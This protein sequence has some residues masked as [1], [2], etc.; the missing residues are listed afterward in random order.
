VVAQIPDTFIGAA[1]NVAYVA[2]A[3][4]DISETNPLVT[5]SRDITDT[6]TTATDND[7]QADLTVV[8]VSPVV[9]ALAR[10]GS[11]VELVALLAG[12]TCVV[13]GLVAVG[14]ARRR[15]AA[16]RI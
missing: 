2:A 6:S 3:P 10:T 4:S 5:P 7:A 14:V 15:A 13:G 1:H 8:A 11:P 12:L 9:L 16:R